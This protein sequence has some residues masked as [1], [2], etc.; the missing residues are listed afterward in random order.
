M[1]KIAFFGPINPTRSGIADYDEELLP[2]LRRH[3]EIDVFTEKGDPNRERV[4]PHGTFIERF[5]REPYDLNLYQLGNSL[6]HEIEYGYLYQYPGAVVFHDYVLHHARAKMLMLKGLV[7]EYQDEVRC[8]H[9]EEPRLAKSMYGGLVGDLLLYYYPF[10]KLV[11]QA[12]LA[13]GAHTDVIAQKLRV[14]NTPVVKIPMFVDVDPVSDSSSLYPGRIV[15]A[16]FGLATPE[17]RINK[18]LNVL[19]DL[20]WYY[21]SLLFL[22]VGEVA[23]H[24]SLRE[25]VKRREMQEF[26]EITGHVD[27]A[28]FH[29]LMTRSDIVINLRY[30]SA[31]EMSAT[32]LRALAYGKPVLMSR[33]EH[34]QE[35][36]ED[37]AI[38]VRPDREEEDLFHHLWQLVESSS[39]RERYG[40]SAQR[41]MQE[42]HRP[43]QTVEK[44][45]E[46]IETALA[47][48]AD[49]RKPL[50][51]VHL[52]SGRDLLR[53]YIRRNSFNGQETPLLDWIL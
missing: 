18:V 6:I 20:R 51:P 52:R 44:Y 7:E 42:H 25:E 23:T 22:I 40:I 10:V 8:A 43:E 39:M 41:Y 16:S 15:L 35:I 24:Y 12:S 30:P 11:L 3:Y 53:D 17:K 49:F 5:R 38:R 26:V 48:K 50:L 19:G 37:A 45:R 32:L 13:A 1:K 21:P 14:T 36:P 2:L 31:G 47:R 34:L 29:R 33:L 46:L 9:P 4:F 27:R 28:Q